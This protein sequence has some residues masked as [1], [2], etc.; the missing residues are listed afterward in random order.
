MLSSLNRNR[1][2]LIDEQRIL[3]RWIGQDSWEASPGKVLEWQD[4]YP[5][6]GIEG[7]L[8][9]GISAFQGQ[10]EGSKPR[11][12]EV[13][14]ERCFTQRKALSF[15]SREPSRVLAGYLSPTPRGRGFPED[16]RNLLDEPDLTP[17]PFPHPW[18]FTKAPL[19]VASL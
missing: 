2:E 16:R 10:G 4:V 11:G 19:E 3:L 15:R 13:Q 9:W 8:I 7:K 17:C 12:R 18:R 1:V 14:G 5:G 6:K